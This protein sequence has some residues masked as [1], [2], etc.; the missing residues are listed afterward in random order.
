M[1][2]RGTTMRFYLAP[3]EEVTGY[4]FRNLVSEMFG[5]YDKV[6]APF[7]TPAATK[8]IFRTRDLRDLDP[9]NNAGRNLVPQMLT[10]DPDRFMDGA[11]VLC[12]MGWREVNLNI[13]CPSNTVVA[14]NRGSGMLRD[15][16]MLDDFLGKI[17]KRVN[18]TWGDEFLISAKIRVGIKDPEEFAGIYEVLARHPFSE[19]I[20]H[21]RVQ[22]DF[23]KNSPHMEAFD[24]A[25]ADP[26]APL[27]YNGD[28]LTV[29]DLRQF[30]ERYPS[31]ECIML[32]RGV[33]RNP[34]FLREIKTG[35]AI[36]MAERKEFH[37]R[38]FEG[39]LDMLGAPKDV[40]FKMKE[41]WYYWQ[42]AFPGQERAIRNILHT[43]KPD[44]YRQMT[45]LL[46]G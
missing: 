28:I 32:G 40:L 46:L 21:P 35:E 10:N 36:T 6:F 24:I 29:E 38:L 26:S 15:V 45:R 39:Y 42:Y 16:A 9:G 17:F 11:K 7:A 43:K 5:E 1:K 3:L 18:E 27:C 34:A 2:I 31:V 41:I 8:R 19:L 22:K 14:K 33:V 13:G 4:V 25:A 12:N 30:S 23:Y 37:D 20:I 44:E